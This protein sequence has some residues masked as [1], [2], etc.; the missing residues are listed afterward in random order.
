MKKV[1]LIILGLFVALILTAIIPNFVKEEKIE[2][3]KNSETV[4][5]SNNEKYD[6]NKEDSYVQPSFDKKIDYKIIDK[7]APTL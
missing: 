4:E 6:S 5:L 1:P 2:I 3:E 7:K